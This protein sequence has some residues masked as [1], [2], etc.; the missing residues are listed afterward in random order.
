MY[1][2]GIQEIKIYSAIPLLIFPA[3]QLVAIGRGWDFE[4]L[5]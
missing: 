5:I 2:C 1:T 4:S 3:V